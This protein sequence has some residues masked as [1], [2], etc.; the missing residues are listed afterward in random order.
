MHGRA[1]HLHA[2][3]ES[4]P[5]RIEALESRQQGRVDVENSTLPLLDETGGQQPHEAGKTDDIDAMLFKH[6]LQGALEGCAVLSES[7]VVDDL[8]GY[9]IG[10]CDHEAARIRTI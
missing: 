5:V 3:L 2:R 10:P 7:G 9:S 1:V 8:G 4:P 6:G